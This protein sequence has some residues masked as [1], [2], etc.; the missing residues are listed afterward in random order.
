MANACKILDKKGF[1]N[2]A[3][4]VQDEDGI[5]YPAGFE[6][7]GTVHGNNGDDEETGKILYDDLTDTGYNI[8]INYFPLV[9]L[10]VVYSEY[11]KIA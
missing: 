4:G 10:R 6:E 7:D 8:K 3:T 11:R 2:F 1:V 5:P 9:C